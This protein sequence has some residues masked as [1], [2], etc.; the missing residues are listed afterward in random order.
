MVA[1]DIDNMVSYCG[2]GPGKVSSHTK[3]DFQ[4]HPTTFA[5]IEFP[6]VDMTA[7]IPMGD[8][9]VLEKLRPVVSA[10]RARELVKRLRDQPGNYL[11]RTWDRRKEIALLA[12]SSPD[13][14]DWAQL[15]SDFAFTEQQGVSM[16]IS[17]INVIDKASKMF[18]AEVAC[19]TKTSYRQ[20][21]REI[22][23]IYTAATTTEWVI[24]SEASDSVALTV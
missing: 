1:L 7:Q 12:L 2:L 5:V 3:R 4:G 20:R 11:A 10:K 13:C 21:W 16:A 23:D 14:E 8:E 19:A 6:H 24:S 22:Q 18:A 15:L 9:K 17:D